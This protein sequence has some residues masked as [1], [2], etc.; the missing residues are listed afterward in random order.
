MREHRSAG[1]LPPGV[2]PEAFAQTV[3]SATVLGEP[4]DESRLALDG[5]RQLT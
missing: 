1:E 4:G 5:S 2:G 3:S